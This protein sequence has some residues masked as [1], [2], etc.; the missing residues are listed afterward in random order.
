MSLCTH[1]LLLRGN[2]N[3]WEKIYVWKYFDEGA[4]PMMNLKFDEMRYNNAYSLV[5]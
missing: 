2:Q 5:N 4:V 1:I 3:M